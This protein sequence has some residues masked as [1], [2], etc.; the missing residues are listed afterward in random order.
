MMLL[1]IVD[2]APCVNASHH[3]LRRH[4]RSPV[5]TATPTSSLTPIVLITGGTGII[6]S[7]TGQTF[8]VLDT[9]EI[10]DPTHGL[11]RPRGALT[12]HRDRAAAVRLHDGR[13]LIVGGVD[14]VPV[15]MASFSGPAMPWI[16]L[17]TDLF[18]PANGHFSA[19]AQMKTA[20]DEPTA[21][22]LKD[23]S[24]LIVG[25]GASNAELFD[26]ATNR[27]APSGEMAASRYEQT[28]TMLQSGKVLIAGGGPATS[29]LYDASADK[30][31]PAGQMDTTRIY[32]T[33]SLLVDGRVLIAGGSQYAR[34]AATNATAIYNPES[35]TW[36]AGPKMVEARV[37]HTAT[38]LNDGK[39][40][41]A[42]GCSDRS[43]E[44]YDPSG[45]KFALTGHMT[46]SRYGHSAT[47]LPDGKVLIAGGWDSQYKP[48]VSAE[49]YD[50]AARK[51]VPT[52]NMTEARAGHTAT[53]IWV[54]RSA[55]W[56]K[57][58]TI[59]PQTATA[60]STPDF[61]H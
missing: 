31:I 17:S 21:T 48:V 58:T 37:S 29:E 3:R 41:L 25:G 51:F 34:S 2:I 20:R 28:A 43:A 54:L 10:F 24:V 9:A 8:A 22:L 32:H 6:S 45:G 26:P 40:L 7:P 55:N 19:A 52:S 61:R 16:L 50:P 18:D 57:P 30:F 27:F 49:L 4:V 5:P 38:T 53:L 13:V 11:F 33:A 35:G 56:L 23:G 14:T 42:G 47:L 46:I 36:E 15:P 1:L 12:T 39:I 59:A 44:L 60:V